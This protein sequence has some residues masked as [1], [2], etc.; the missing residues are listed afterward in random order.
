MEVNHYKW[1]RELLV[2]GFFLEYSKVLFKW[3]H[4]LS[5]MEAYIH[6]WFAQFIHSDNKFIISI[7]HHFPDKAVLCNEWL[8]LHGGESF[9]MD[10]NGL[11]TLV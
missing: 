7:S 3:E 5:V 8:K 11:G 2:Y 4:S 9:H 10:H 6:K 1:K